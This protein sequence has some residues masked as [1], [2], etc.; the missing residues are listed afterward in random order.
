MRSSD[1]CLPPILL[2][3]HRSNLEF[4][5]NTQLGSH[6][7][8]TKH[9][10]Y[11][12]DNRKIPTFPP[13]SH[14]RALKTR[15]YT[16]LRSFTQEFQHPWSISLSYARGNKPGWAISCLMACDQ[17]T[18]IPLAPFPLKYYYLPSNSSPLQEKNPSWSVLL[19]NRCEG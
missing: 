1:H 13:F 6:T 7:E 18:S 11:S 17:L 5:E 8:V 19:P 16:N 14:S 2:T 9:K 4:S 12:R 15:L 3:S 10:P